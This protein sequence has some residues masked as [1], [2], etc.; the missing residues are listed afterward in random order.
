MWILGTVWACESEAGA[1]SNRAVRSP[2]LSIA[3]TPDSAALIRKMGGLDRVF[4]EPQGMCLEYRGKRLCGREQGTTQTL[5]Q[6]DSG[7][8]LPA[9]RRSGTVTRSHQLGLCLPRGLPLP[10]QP[11][12][13]PQDL[14]AR[15]RPGRPCS[16]IFTAPEFRR[17]RSPTGSGPPE[18]GPA[19]RAWRPRKEVFIKNPWAQAKGGGWSEAGQYHHPLCQ[20]PGRPSFA[21]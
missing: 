1:T 8:T 17:S 15:A 3:V 2:G 12:E 5:R 21:S 20:A 10:P 16:P 11:R 19:C 7:L 4:L 13:K 9:D 6:P 14:A 18:H